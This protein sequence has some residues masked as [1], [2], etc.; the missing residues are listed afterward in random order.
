MGGGEGGGE[1]C[2]TTGWDAEDGFFP[3]S[4][5]VLLVSPQD[6]FLQGIHLAACAGVPA[7]DEAHG[8]A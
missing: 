3:F 2:G 1:G 6:V 7:P 5:N 4:P 8:A